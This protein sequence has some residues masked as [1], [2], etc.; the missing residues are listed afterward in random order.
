[1]R[2]TLRAVVP[3]ALAAVGLASILP[4]P[5]DAAPTAASRSAKLPSAPVDVKLAATLTG[6]DLRWTPAPDANDDAV[7][8]YNIHRVGFDGVDTVVPWQPAWNDVGYQWHESRTVPG[9]TYSVTAVNAEGEGAAS[10]PIRRPTVNRSIT[11][12]HTVW[13]ENGNTLTYAGQIA[14]PNGQQVVPIAPDGP[15]QV[16]GD[17]VASSP[18]GRELAFVR[19]QS[20]IW[21]TGADFSPGAPVK[22]L[23]GSSGIIRLAYSP[24]ESKIAYER[25]QPDSSS[26]IEIVPRLG[27]TPVQVGCGLSMPTWSPDGS[28]LIVKDAATSRLARVQPRAG[29]A[30][31]GTYAGTEQG[32]MPTAS[33][34]GRWIGYIDGNAPAV[35]PVGGGTPRR[36]TPTEQRP[37]YLSW[38]PDG[39]ELLMTQPIAFGGSALVDLPVGTD[40]SVGAGRTVYRTQGTDRIGSAMWQGPRAMISPTYGPSGPN[41]LMLFDGGVASRTYCQFDAEPY[42]PCAGEFVRNNVPT[43]LHTLRLKAIDGEDHAS[44]SF[45]TV[46]V[47]ATPP[48]VRI[49]GPAFDATTAPT[50]TVTYTAADNSGTPVKSYDSRWRIAPTAG[51]FGG[52]APVKS[53]TSATSVQIGLVPGYEYCVSVRARDGFGNVSAWTADRCFSRPSDDRAMSVTAGWTRASNRVYYLGTATSTKAAGVAIAR[54]SVQAKRLFLVATR[55]STCGA[56]TVY[57]NGKAVGTVNLASASLAYQ[58]IVPLPVPATFLTG[59]VLLRTTTAGKVYQI[60]GLAVRRT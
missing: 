37:T 10:T 58:A 31:L 24:D 33:P 13:L 3:I 8:G 55:C 46:N 48:N 59:S 19:G 40:G 30:I 26:C 22:V 41:V 35:I 16:I 39:T 45:H 12:G 57:Y 52:Y 15:T 29:G 1:M 5:A 53:G 14:D 20:E 36:G 18:D 50:A 47:D 54:S 42:A 49:T 11:V 25:L 43:G 9:A 44:V 23:G 32:I 4:T 28:E 51:A 2:I 60:D 27:G 56:L 6:I 17:V 21:R 34:D 38:Y 7:T